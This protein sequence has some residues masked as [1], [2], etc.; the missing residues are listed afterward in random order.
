VPAPAPAN[1]PA[2]ED[3][4][5]VVVLP[6]LDL[7]GQ[8]SSVAARA[9]ALL[10]HGLA[11]Y[12]R[13]RVVRGEQTIQQL[14]SR[15]A[16]AEKLGFAREF[17]RL[18]RRDYERIRLAEAVKHLQTAARTYRAVH[19]ELVAPREVAQTLLTLAKA[20]LEQGAEG[21]AEQ[22][23]QQLLSI[24]PS[25]RLTAGRF[26]EPVI[27]VFD[28]ARY[29][30]ARNPGAGISAETSITVARSLGA[31]YVVTGHLRPR[32]EPGSL[33]VGVWMY[34]VRRQVPV[35]K[36]QRVPADTP[37]GLTGQLDRLTSRLAACVPNRTYLAWQRNPKRFEPGLFVD[38]SFWQGTHLQHP[39]Q[40]GIHE[41][42]L[43]T[44]VLWAPQR[45]LV[46]LGRFGFIAA[47]NNRPYED[48]LEE[49]HLLRLLLGAGAG[50]VGT[51]GAIYSVVGFDFALNF[52]YSW[53]HAADCKW[54]DPPPSACAEQ[55]ERVD[56]AL[57]F[58][59]HGGVGGHWSFAPPLFVR[60]RL[61]LSYYLLEPEQ[62]ELNLPV[63]W[64]V[65]L[66]Y[67]F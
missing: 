24:D 18:G 41:L 13:L 8:S 15:S 32:P 31:D 19:H 53:T 36:L 29:H 63:D 65:G 10:E 57:A 16:Y 66:G 40:S 38:T 56:L 26:A 45:N 47:R 42:G 64:E 6:V 22:A 51:R 28:K 58:G 5:T 1:L 30:T 55:I 67:R 54:H 50:L 17:A 20:H 23:F 49:M 59:V 21:P 7:S 3:P 43:S 27:A 33:S 14:A 60:G 9:T 2:V 25:V 12:A 4:R 46:V 52:P 48:L 44:G 11:R 39:L 62:T 34:D 37:E 61:G 35:T